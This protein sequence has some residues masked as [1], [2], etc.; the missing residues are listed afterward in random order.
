MPKKT[1]S[2]SDHQ[3]AFEV[4]YTSK[5]WSRV[6]DVIGCTYATVFRWADKSFPCQEG[7]PWHGWEELIKER[8]RVLHAQMAAMDTGGLIAADRASIETTKQMTVKKRQAIFQLLKSDVDRIAHLELLYSKTFYELTGIPLDKNFFQD[9]DGNLIDM[10]QIYGQ[11]KTVRDLEAGMRT[12]S[13]IMDQI[14]QLKVRAGLVDESGQD[15]SHL[16]LETG[17]PKDRPLS[18]HDLRE[19]KHRLENTSPEQLQAMKAIID[20]DSKAIAGVE[21]VGTNS[22]STI[23]PA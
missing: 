20:A 10:D 17:D 2:A 6:S 16:Q 13:L 9:R 1:Y 3:R 4:Y 23:S 5:V 21:S 19:M 22:G 7:C 18:L 12:L 8:D 11:G 15:K 14:D